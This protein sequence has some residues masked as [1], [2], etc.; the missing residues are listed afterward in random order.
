MSRARWP[1][2][3]VPRSTPQHEHAGRHR[4]ERARVAD[5]AGAQDPPQPGDHVV[6]G[7][8]G[9]LVD[10][11]ESGVHADDSPNSLDSRRPLPQHLLLVGHIEAMAVGHVLPDG[12][13]LFADVSFRVGEGA[14]VALVGPNGAGKTT[15]LRM[16]AGDLPVQ[17][18][19]I[20]RSG[21]LGVMRQFIGMIGDDSHARR[22]G[23]ARWPRRRVPRAAGRHRRAACGP[24]RLRG[25]YEH[26]AGKAQLALRRRAR[27]LGRGRRV[28]RRGA[29]RHA[30]RRR[31]RTCPGRRR[32]T[33]RSRTLSGGAAEA[34]RAGAAAAR[35]RRG[36][37]ARRA[38]Q[39][40][41]RTRQALAG[42]AA[43]R[44]RQVRAVRL[45]RPGTAGPDR[46]PGGHRR[47]RHGLDPPAAASRPGTRPG[48]PAT[49][50]STSCAAAGTRST[51]SS[52]ELVL[53]YKQKAAV[54][55]RHGLALPGRAD[56]AAQVR[57]GRAAAE[58]R[59]RSRTSGCGWPAG[60]PASAR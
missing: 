60:V 19:A 50:G 31:A 9:G 23:A 12:R 47:G 44:V 32:G 56:P 37:A 45:A 55:R 22:P 40:P 58:L 5:L 18:G 21:G 59:R 20:A 39:L 52:S 11:H 41:R 49:T 2:S 24:P 6:A 27:R 16:V 35:P 33:G 17:T 10:D 29:L 53:M 8:P 38:R 34:V 1:S 3:F 43:A 36:A 54:Q 46:R 7:Q 4:V 42:G 25:K 15:L 48:W 51:R 28:R 14:K 57:G 30:S 13:E 26:R